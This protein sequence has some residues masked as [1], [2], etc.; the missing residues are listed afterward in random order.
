[1]ADSAAS[2]PEKLPKPVAM[3]GI[4]NGSIEITTASPEARA[5]F[6]QGLNLFHDFWDYESSRAFEQAIR[7]DPTCA[8]CFWGLYQAES[9][10]N[11]NDAWGAAALKQ[12][13]KL[14]PH[15]TPAERLYIKAAVQ[16]E[17]ERQRAKSH[18]PAANSKGWSIEGAAAQRHID[19]K[20]TK[21]LRKL[22]ALRPEDTQ[23]RILLAESLIDGFDKEQKPKPGTAEAQAILASILA[24]HPDDSAAN[25]YWIHAQE[26]GLH[27]EYALPSARKLSAL[28][29]TSGH[30]VHMPGHIFYRMGDYETGR[31]S[32]LAS[33][34]ADET[35]MQ[36]QSV[37]VDNDWN[38][39]HNLMYLIAD[40]LEAGRLEE[41][42]SSSAKL[43][44]AR[45]QRRS[46]LYIN[47]SRDGIARLD[48]LL[49][50]ALRSADWARASALLEA[51]HPAAE[52]PN[53]ITLRD[54]LLDYTRGMAALADSDTASAQA[55]SKAIDDRLAK[56]PPEPA[57]RMP[58]MSA[59]AGPMARDALIGPLHSYL[60]VA[61]LELRASVQ[62]A[63]GHTADADATFTKAAD[64]ERALGYHE[65]PFYIRPV[66]ET[67]GDALLRA[68]R[69]SNAK[70][71]Y[72]AALKERPNSGFPLYGIAQ[73][74]AAA[75]NKDAAAE[76][77]RA[78]LAAWKN[79]DPALPQ[80][81]AAKQWSE[82]GGA[83]A[84]K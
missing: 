25:H 19:S 43:T 1:M 27:P 50:V 38:Y 68:K 51:S 40:L 10:R 75:G 26:A 45:G 72:Q 28:T 65:P 62:L 32:F 7:V 49:P 23:A 12:A 76:E 67:R 16:S 46:T 6:T 13:R 74:D 3:S 42:T 77:F 2:P 17:K 79:A 24:A 11:E 64:A 57:M 69:Y 48:P 20:E 81:V 73:A 63:Q 61:A 21:L 22:I 54:A 41:A 47:N 29:P 39:V 56:L 44:E 82:A 31:L 33:T 5:W 14:A 84:S 59:S 53:L 8:M 78:L 70:S 18:A 9:F 71:A 80:V 34:R 58:G 35:Y 60:D 83:V 66:G 52:L 30:M 15:A 4:G 55:R 36:A 37:S